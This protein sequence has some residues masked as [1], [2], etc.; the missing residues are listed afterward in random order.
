MIT[1]H[2]Y[3]KTMQALVC[4]HIPHATIALNMSCIFYHKSH[5]ICMLHIQHDMTF[6]HCISFDT[7]EMML[8]MYVVCENNKDRCRNIIP[9]LVEHLIKRAPMSGRIPTCMMST[10]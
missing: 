3:H 1:Y 9:R 8:V 5:M 10:L 2:E 4:K 6:F 7:L